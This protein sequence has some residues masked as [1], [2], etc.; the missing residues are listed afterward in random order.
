MGLK[1]R[2]RITAKRMGSRMGAARRIP[3]NTTTVAARSSITRKKEGWRSAVVMVL[4]MP[5]LSSTEPFEAPFM[6]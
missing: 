3:V 1:S 5:D 2:A 4:S 6:T